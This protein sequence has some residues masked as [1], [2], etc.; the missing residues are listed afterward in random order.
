[1]SPL[2]ECFISNSIGL[3]L[4]GDAE[5]GVVVRGDVL[6]VQAV[7]VVQLFAVLGE[8]LLRRR[9][10]P[11]RPSIVIYEIKGPSICIENFTVTPTDFN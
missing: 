2:E 7:E 1:M 4:E 11:G 6:F 3:I 5:V 9:C 8:W 10:F